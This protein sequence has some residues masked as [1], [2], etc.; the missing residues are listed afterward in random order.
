MKNFEKSP[1]S[2]AFILLT[3]LF[4]LVNQS[5]PEKQNGEVI[6]DEY[7]LNTN[8]LVIKNFVNLQEQF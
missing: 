2:D 6:Q 5:F 7:F 3:S 8:L 4:S 1:T